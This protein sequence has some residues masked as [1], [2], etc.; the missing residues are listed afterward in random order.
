MGHL[1]AIHLLPSNVGTGGGRPLFWHALAA[2]A[3]LGFTEAT[4]GAYEENVRA[5]G[6]YEAMGWH[7]EGP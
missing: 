3:V 5:R 1:D 7:E 4:L 2:M 6:F